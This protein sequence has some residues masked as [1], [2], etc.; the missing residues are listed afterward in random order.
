MSYEDNLS[1]Y[2]EYVA[3]ADKDQFEGNEFG[4][5]GE[6]KNG[7][8]G[9]FTIEISKLCAAAVKGISDK[10][11][12]IAEIK[13]WKEQACEVDL[14]YMCVFSEMLKGENCKLGSNISSEALRVFKELKASN[15]RLRTAATRYLDPKHT[16]TMIDL[17]ESAA[18]LEQAI[19]ETP[20]QSL[21]EIEA[22]A[23][24][25]AIEECKDNMDKDG[26]R[27]LCRVVD[28]NAHA[29]NVRGRRL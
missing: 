4:I 11:K 16:S 29:N 1:W 21:K 18:L 13:A 5:Y 26:E 9:V 12:E 14:A 6:G 23:I 3:A 2:L 19:S 24:V 7:V 27:W 22:D 28:L 25:K 10:D 17:K 8:E 15:E 20:A